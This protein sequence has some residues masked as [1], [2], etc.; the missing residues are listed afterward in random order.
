MTSLGER[1]FL[2]A[3]P[4]WDR[5]ALAISVGLTLL[6]SALMIPTW[7]RALEELEPHRTSWAAGVGIAYTIAYLVC[8]AVG[9]W[10]A[11]V[12]RAVMCLTLMG[13]GTVLILLMG[14]TNSWV[15][16]FALCVIAVTASRE[17][18]VVVTVL[19]L[20]GIAVGALLTGIFVEQLTNLVVLGSVSSAIALL[21]RLVDANDELKR[22]R[23]QIA[24]L[25]V[26]R[27]RERVAR[28]LH[29]ILGHS[30]TTITVKAGLVR[31]LLES[32]DDLGAAAREAGDVERLSRQALADVRATVSGYR[33]ITLSGELASAREVLR[34]AGIQDRLPQAVDDVHP[35]LQ[36]VFG[37]ILREAVTNAVRHSSAQRVTVAIGTNWLRVD[38]DGVGP[39]AVPWGNGLRGLEERMQAVEGTLAA[40]ARPQGGFFV[41]AVVPALASGSGPEQ[42]KTGM[43][44][45]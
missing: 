12:V 24:L 11:W 10:E 19:A 20:A 16:M 42:P 14:L 5:R 32:S 1:L 22:T 18:A 3:S 28:D 39:A 9:P 25:A 34:A 13:L 40:G 8:V 6:F 36:E 45:G 27:E 37:H 2:P 23:D 29:D 21:A 31:R 44:R 43:R 41:H 7:L 30:L 38:D 15:L 35:S 33:Q 4:R 17:V 26:D